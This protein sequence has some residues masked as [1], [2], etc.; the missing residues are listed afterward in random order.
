MRYYRVHGKTFDSIETAVRY[1][2]LLK[3]SNVLQAARL[4]YLDAAVEKSDYH[5]AK[6]VIKYIMEKQS[7]K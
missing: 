1:M 3:I 5:E 4:D 7:E 6:E 2:E